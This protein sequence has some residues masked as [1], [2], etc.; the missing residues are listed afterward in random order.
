VNREIEDDGRWRIELTQVEVTPDIVRVT[1]TY[2][3][4]GSE[5]TGLTCRGYSGLQNAFFYFSGRRIYATDTFCHENPD[6]DAGLQPGEIL[7]SW[8]IFPNEFE[9]GKPP[10]SLQWFSFPSV[11]GIDFS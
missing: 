3:N 11:V 6:Y 1:V 4:Y 10:Y 7:E 5:F 2:N 8:A 9:T